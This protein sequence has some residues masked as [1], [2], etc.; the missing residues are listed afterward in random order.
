MSAATFHL[1]A[2]TVRGSGTL[3]V[4]WGQLPPARILARVLRLP[5]EGPA[6][7][8]RVEIERMGDQEVWRRWFA[9]RPYVTRQS[10]RG[11]VRIE[12][13]GALEIRYRLLAS[14]SEVRYVQE[15]ACLR[16]GRLAI[17]LPQRLSPIVSAEAAGPEEDRFFVAVMVRAPL[18]GS[19]LSYSGCVIEEG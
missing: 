14:P 4:R 5:P 17:P 13:I 3:S 6:V 16:M 11:R 1:G 15:G 18:V 9:G 7:P 2:E 19:L 10:R 12:R 8:V